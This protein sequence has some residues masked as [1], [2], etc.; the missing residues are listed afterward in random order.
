MEY[1]GVFL[2]V[3]RNENGIIAGKGGFPGNNQ[4]TNLLGFAKIKLY[5]FIS[6]GR[7]RPTGLFVTIDK[8]FGGT[9]LFPIGYVVCIF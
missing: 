4:G 6:S 9:C 3:V 2:I 8:I 1:A 5:P 7:C